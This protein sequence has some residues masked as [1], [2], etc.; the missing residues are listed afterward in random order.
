MSHQAHTAHGQLIEAAHFAGY[1]FE[2]VLNHMEWLLT[3]GRWRELGF[4]DINEFYASIKLDNMRLLAE[5]RKKLVKLMAAQEKASQR[6]IGRTLGVDQQTV[7]GDLGRREDLSS[8]SPDHGTTKADEDAAAEGKSSPTLSGSEA[9]KAVAKAERKA[10]AIEE[11]KAERSRLAAEAVRVLPPGEDFGVVHGDFRDHSPANDSAGLLF[12]DLAYDRESLLILAD[13][14]ATAVR[15]LR[16]GGSLVTYGG[17]YSLPTFM[18]EAEPFQL[19]FCWPLALVLGGPSNRLNHY[20]LLVKHKQLLWWMKPGA[21]RRGT[22]MHSVIQGQGRDKG[23][24]DWQQGVSEAAYCI[25]HLT[26]PGDLVFDPFCGSGTTLVAA[27]QLGRRWLG[28]D[29]DQDAV[30]IARNRIRKAAVED[31]AQVAGRVG[32]E[33]AA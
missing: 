21:Q 2:R 16:P 13:L 6:Q 31:V 22:W 8:P 17:D 1:T 5:Q 29:I 20:R 33:D 3:D 9:S 11:A 23:L 30:A 28:C 15:V 27:Q 18:R 19:E 32:P 7:R 4:E 26:E 10:A 24:H 14:F 25:E 12:T